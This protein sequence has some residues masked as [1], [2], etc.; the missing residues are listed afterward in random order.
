MKKLFAPITLFAIMAAF[1]PQTADAQIL[2]SVTLSKTSLS[3]TDTS[4]GTITADDYVRSFTVVA[5]KTG[6]SPT[7]KVYFYGSGDGTNYDLLDSLAVANVAGAQYKTFKPALPQVYYKY[8]IAA[9]TAG[10]AL[11]LSA[12]QLSRSH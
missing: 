8:K 9:Y 5:T 10:G 11:T 4:T 3:G 12:K 6:S 7:G 2:R 1:A